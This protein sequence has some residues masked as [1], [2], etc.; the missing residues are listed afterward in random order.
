MDTQEMMVG[1]VELITGHET[2]KAITRQYSCQD[3]SETLE[4]EEIP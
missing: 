4:L 2:K 1:Q 3:K